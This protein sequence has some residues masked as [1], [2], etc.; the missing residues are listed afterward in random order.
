MKKGFISFLLL[1][2][3]F[4]LMTGC[5]TAK[6]ESQQLISIGITQI[7]QHDAL[8][9]VRKGILDGL[10]SNGFR[11]GE[12]IKV[13]YQD[14][15]NEINNAI[16]IA[17]NFAADKK[18]MIIAISTPSAQAAAQATQ[19]IP[20]VFAT[21]TDPVA[22]GLVDSLDKTDG[23]ITGTSDQLPMELQVDLIRKFIPDIKKLGVIYSTSEVNAGV[24]ADQIEE[25]AAT[26]GIEIVRAGITTTS[27]VKVATESLIGKVE[28][29]LIPVDNTV[30][31]AI[32]GVL[33]VAQ[34]AKIPVFA[35][36][37][38]TVRH[39]AV[40]TYGI[41]YY[42]MG[43]QT[44]EMAARILKGE[45]ISENPVEVTK[46]VDLTINKKA[47]KLFELPVPSELEKEAKEI[48]E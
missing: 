33:S 46:N 9:S 34:E 7:V 14:A 17:N 30:V 21:V 39:G 13:D 47:A 19:D 11:D 3:L 48:I 35:S 15:Q 4:G 20:I 16:T 26:K 1:L 12:Q 6:P 23:N 28:A 42:K 22:A 44:G 41:D 36:D 18:D 31:S 32:D 27:E 10:A 43:V 5:G 38:D 37:T 2:F 8:D 45:K 40:A 25:S 24:Q 29:I